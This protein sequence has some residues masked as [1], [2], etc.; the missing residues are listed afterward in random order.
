MFNGWNCMSRHLLSILAF[1]LPILASA[2][3]GGKYTYSFLDM[4]ATAKITSMGGNLIT[5]KD[6]DPGQA[7]DNPSLLNSSMDNT[8][9]LS[10]MSYFAGINNG[11]ASYTFHNKLGTFNTALKYIDYGTFR[12]ADAGNNELGTFS[13]NEMV[14][15]GGYGR[16]IDSSFSVGAN[17]K[18]IYSNLYL[19]NSFGMAFDLSASYEIKKYYLLATMVVRNVGFQLKPYVPGEQQ[20]LPADIQFGVSKSFERMP[21]KFSFVVHQLAKGRLTYPGVS[22]QGSGSFGESNDVNNESNFEEVI[23]H[24][25]VATE[26]LPGKN[27]NVRIGYNFQRR[28][29]MQF[30][31]RPATVGLSWGF[32]LKISKLHFSY[33]R[34]AYHL[35]GSPNHITVLTRFSDWSKN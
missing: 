25:I 32:S 6:N 1:F 15:I 33:A 11:F 4:P 34:S 8:V 26:F 30:A 31:D 20:A 21:F 10:Y 23:R 9:V 35:T 22:Q 5:F 12:E 7:S 17:Y 27:F 14:L 16:Q 2:Q 3:V 24:F 13:A 19:Y 29:E 18:L 28:K